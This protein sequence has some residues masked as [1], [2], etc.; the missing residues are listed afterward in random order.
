MHTGATLRLASL[1]I[2]LFCFSP[3]SWATDPPRGV[4]TSALYTY[5]AVGWSF[6]IPRQWRLRTKEEIARVRNVGKEAYEK[7]LNEDTVN[8]DTPVLYLQHETSTR[9]RFTSDAIAY[10]GTAGDYR[11]HQQEQFDSI[12]ALYETMNLHLSEARGTETIGGI[13]FATQRVR[14][15]SRDGKRL[16]MTGMN[17]GALIDGVAFSMG[18]TVDNDADRGIIH[19]AIVKSRFKSARAE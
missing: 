13:T 17:F 2:A 9:S 15:H 10:D 8:I 18:Y 19:D 3:T 5:D 7:L 16:L 12:I 6:Q 11:K 4:V 14:V 1:L